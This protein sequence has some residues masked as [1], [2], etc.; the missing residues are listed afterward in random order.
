MAMA[1]W[2]AAVPQVARMIT[3]GDGNDPAERSRRR[4]SVVAAAQRLAGGA[5]H[6]IGRSQAL[7][8]GSGMPFATG[9]DRDNVVNL[10]EQLRRHRTQTIA[11]SRDQHAYHKRSLG[12]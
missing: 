1:A 7:L 6:V 10:S 11:R 9:M 12:T 5:R 8:R 3:G 2:W 4:A